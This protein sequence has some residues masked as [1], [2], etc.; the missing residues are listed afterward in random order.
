MRIKDL[1][2]EVGEDPLSD[3]DSAPDVT[4]K[5]GGVTNGVDGEPPD[6][7][8]LGGGQQPAQAG[9]GSFNFDAK[10]ADQGTG[11]VSGGMPETPAADDAAASGAD[12]EQDEDEAKRLSPKAISAVKNHDFVTKF[13]HADDPQ[14]APDEI[15]GMDDAT[16]KDAL[17]K[18]VKQKRKIELMTD[19]GLYDDERYQRIV[20]KI[21]FIKKVA[22]AR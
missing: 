18:A 14:G 4:A 20:A 1:L 6:L 15:M 2:R 10:S 9:G 12:E 21:D 13:S 19:A 11:D 7:P 3:A 5:T 22:G 17:A 16:L 8:D